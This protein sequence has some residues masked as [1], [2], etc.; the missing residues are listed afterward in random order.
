MKI[1]IK[2][3]QTNILSNLIRQSQNNSE[4]TFFKKINSFDDLTKLNKKLNYLNQQVCL[5]N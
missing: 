1:D 3:N 2:D 4:E 5:F